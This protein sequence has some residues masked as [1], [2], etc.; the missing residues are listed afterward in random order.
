MHNKKAIWLPLALPLLLVGCG[1]ETPASTPSVTVTPTTT[2]STS[3][4]DEAANDMVVN[5]DEEESFED[6]DEDEELNIEIHDDQVEQVNT[7]NDIIELNDI[8]PV[9]IPAVQAGYV[10]RNVARS[11]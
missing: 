6:K 8:D 11:D 7:L 3:T 1:T 4:L 5:K 10:S 9:D 2:S